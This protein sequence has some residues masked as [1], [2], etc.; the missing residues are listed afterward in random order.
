M[1]LAQIDLKYIRGS[2][3]HGK[4]GLTA[5]TLGIQ[6]N[7]L[8]RKLRGERP[9]TIDE[10]NGIAEF[11]GIG[12]DEFL[13]FEDKDT[14]NEKVAVNGRTFEVTLTPDTEGGGYVVECPTIKGCMSQGDTRAEALEM[15]QD[16]IELC[17]E[18]LEERD[19]GEVT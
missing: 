2:I 18:V 7:T 1:R 17:L 16:A 12:V 19:H 15:I 13:R 11:L 14:P 4:M 10:I 8:S 6:G 3:P 5:K 9:L